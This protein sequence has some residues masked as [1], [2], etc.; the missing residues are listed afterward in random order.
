MLDR[1]MLI[2]YCSDLTQAFS[3]YFY[4]THFLHHVFALESKKELILELDYD[5]TENS[6]RLW[7]F[8][9]T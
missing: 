6:G 7:T 2:P 3:L 1:P 8:L 5:L 9:R 4:T